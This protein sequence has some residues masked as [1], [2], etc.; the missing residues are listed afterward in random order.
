MF[1]ACFKKYLT[2]FVVASLVGT[3]RQNQT[4]TKN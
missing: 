4:I 1:N 2:V 3:T